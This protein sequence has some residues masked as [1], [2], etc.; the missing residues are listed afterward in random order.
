MD[1]CDI[2]QIC[3]IKCGKFV[4]VIESSIQIV[5]VV[6]KNCQNLRSNNQNYL[7]QKNLTENGRIMKQNLTLINY[8]KQDK[9]DRI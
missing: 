3:C 8:I 1:F 4:G 2:K 5:Y 7:N 9:N 6:C